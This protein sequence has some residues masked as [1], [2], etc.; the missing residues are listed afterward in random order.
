MTKFSPN[1]VIKYFIIG[2]LILW[3]GWGVA[4]PF[5]SIFI[6]NSIEGATLFSIGLAVAIYWMTKAA[7]Q[8]PTAL[9]LDRNDGEKDDFYIL[10]IGLCVIGTSV[11]AFV[12]AEKLWQIYLIQFIKAVGFA[13]YIPGWLAIYSRHLDKGHTA[14]EWAVNSSAGAFGIG[15]AGIFGGS[16]ANWFGFEFVFVSTSL[17]AFLSAI[18]LFFSRDFILPKDKIKIIPDKQTIRNQ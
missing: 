13:L 3:T 18:I 8:I 14:F 12:F 9:I 6:I 10:I 5:F 17:L 16:I 4:D 11:L 7:V 15:L 1:R 2:D